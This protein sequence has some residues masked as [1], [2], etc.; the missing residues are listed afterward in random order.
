M[1]CDDCICKRSAEKGVHFV[2]TDIL[3]VAG[4]GV[5]DLVDE[6]AAGSPVQGEHELGEL[7]EVEH[8]V[9]VVVEVVHDVL[10]VDVVPLDDL[11]QALDGGARGSLEVGRLDFTEFLLDDLDELIGIDLTT[12]VSVEHVEEV[13][14][15]VGGEVGVEGLEQLQELFGGQTAVTVGVE[16]GYHVVDI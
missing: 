4:E 1:P 7:V 15:F 5:E 8:L 12:A 16:E 13:V 3:L 9:P 11:L 10:Q 6:F 2:E 14:G